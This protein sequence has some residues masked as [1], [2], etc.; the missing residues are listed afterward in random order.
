LKRPPENIVFQELFLPARLKART[1]RTESSN[2]CAPTIHV[3]ANT[4]PSGGTT[5]HP[6]R[7]LLGTITSASAN[8]GNIDVPTPLYRSQSLVLGDDENT[9]SNVI[10]YSPVTRILQLIDNSGI[11]EDSIVLTFPPVIFADALQ[12]FQ[13]THVD[14]VPIL[15]AHFYFQQTAMPL[16]VA[17]LFIEESIAAIGRRRRARA[18]LKITINTEPRA[19]SRSM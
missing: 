6:R 2:P 13:I 14:Q 4:G 11:F 7:S 12:E 9:S 1:T 15:D 17:E 10:R 5:S 16:Q 18:P 3:T 8:A 19:K